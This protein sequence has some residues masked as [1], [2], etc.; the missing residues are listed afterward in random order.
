MEDNSLSNGSTNV[1]S[2]LLSSVPLKYLFVESL[3]FSCN[4]N[5]FCV[6]FKSLINLVNNDTGIVERICI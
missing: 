2:L 4:W 1:A 3:F 6:S 5:G